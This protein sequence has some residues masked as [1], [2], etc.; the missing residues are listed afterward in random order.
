MIQQSGEVLGPCSH[1]FDPHQNGV[2]RLLYSEPK[3][4]ISPI[5]FSLEMLC[6][7]HFR[8]LTIIVDPQYHLTLTKN[9]RLFVIMIFGS[10]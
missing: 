3:Y 10:T 1:D 9:N 7:Q 2:F 4:T 6:V 8:R 5:W